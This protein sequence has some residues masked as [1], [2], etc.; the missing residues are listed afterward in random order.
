LVFFF[1]QALL[2]SSSVLFFVFVFCYY[3]LSLIRV[4]EVTCD[5]ST[6][7]MDSFPQQPLTANSSSGVGVSWA[8]SL[9]TMKYEILMGSI[10]YCELVSTAVM[11][12]VEDS[13][14]Q[15]C[16]FFF[17]PAPYNS[18]MFFQPWRGWSRCPK[19]LGLSSQHLFFQ[20]WIA[21]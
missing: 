21:Y 4:D 2:L 5:Y 6:E 16:L 3:P 7:E 14:S 20:L 1:Q 15:F 17:F 10:C 11:S 19:C 9:S 13:I 12:W 18:M 8:P